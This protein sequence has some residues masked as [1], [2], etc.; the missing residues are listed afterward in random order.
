M[1]SVLDPSSAAGAASAYRKLQP[2]WCGLSKQEIAEDQR[3]RI[4]EAMAEIASHRGYQATTIKAVCALAGVSRRTFYDLFGG[5]PRDPRQTCFLE[6]YDF[7][8]ERAVAHISEAYRRERD[9]DRRLC[10]AFEQFAAEAA[11]EPQAAR[12]ALIEAFGA[13]PVALQRMG[14]GRAI[15]EGLIEASVN[16]RSRGATLSPRIAKG[17]AG[18]VERIARVYLLEGRI[19]ELSAT[20]GELSAWVS[21]YRPWSRP[22]PALASQAWRA[23]PPAVRGKDDGL[24]IHRAAATIAASEGYSALSAPRISRVAEV[25][26][27]AFA[28]MYDGPGAV[29]K[30]FLAAFD[31]LG[32]EALVCAARAARPAAEWPQGV[33]DGIA[34][35]LNHVASNPFVGQ[36]VFV[37]I[38]AV[39]PAAVEPRSKL[40]RRFADV[41]IRRIPEEQRPSELL[42]EA[43]VGAVWA[44]I[45][46]YVARGQVHRLRELADDATYLALTPIIGSDPAIKAIL[47]D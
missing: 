11:G 38:F 15:F 6:T 10:R 5:G 22:T 23:R 47:A 7:V 29:E 17:I 30:C 21:S 3:Q 18:G 40:L 14:E 16:N 36:V 25:S 44:V 8:V 41:F 31:L 33:R 13:G 20:A 39:G 24:R 37:E 2:R 26:E 32:V 28:S 45:H 42:A 35:L 34:A 4:Y 43:I 12:L 46:D 19:D 1:S 27:E 9:P